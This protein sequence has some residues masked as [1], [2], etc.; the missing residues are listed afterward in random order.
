MRVGE[1]AA[2]ERE[3]VGKLGRGEAGRGGVGRSARAGP[4]GEKKGVLGQVRDGVRAAAGLGFLS[5]VL[6]KG[7]PL[8]FSILFL[9]Q[10]KLK[11]FEFKFDFEFKPHSIN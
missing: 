4:V 5:G 3:G 8:P 10:T 1:R 2:W 11:L 6:A 7:F 9:F